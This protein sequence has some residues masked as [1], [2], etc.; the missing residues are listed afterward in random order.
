MA[1]MCSDNCRAD[2]AK[3]MSSSAMEHVPAAERVA[4]LEGRHLLLQ[5]HLDDIPFSMGHLLADG[6]LRGSE[7]EIWTVFGKEFFN[8]RDYPQD[9]QTSRL[10]Q[11]EERRWFAQEGHPLRRLELEEA[12][13]RGV[14][15]VRRL[16]RT[17]L[18]QQAALNY[19]SL[20]YGNWQ[21][22]LEAVREL[23]RQA[24]YVWVPAGI[25][26]HCDHLALRQAALQAAR[27]EPAIR[28]LLFYHEL[29]YSLYS[30]EIDWDQFEI[31][32]FRQEEGLTHQPTDAEARRKQE[33]IGVFY[34]QITD[35]QAGVLARHTEKVAIWARRET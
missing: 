8:I 11:E 31:D 17:G 6:L 9:E 26:G 20:G 22:V 5:P 13:Y 35:R 30:R 4:R 18:Y 27:L 1:R 2:R 24:A 12:G 21:A 3:P 7:Y 32:G 34:S 25:G 33:S 14:T 29:P 28:G 19:D 16:F 23:G 10:L 15:G